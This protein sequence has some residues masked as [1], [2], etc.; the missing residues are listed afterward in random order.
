[1]KNIEDYLAQTV[2]LISESE[3]IKMS[4]LARELLGTGKASLTLA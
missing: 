3:T 2:S 1:M 4:K